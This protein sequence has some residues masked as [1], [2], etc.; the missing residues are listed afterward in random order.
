MRK[1][2]TPV[3]GWEQE[4]ADERPSEFRGSTGYSVLSG[5]HLPSELN[6]RAARRRRGTGMGFKLVVI[7]FLALLAV[8]GVAIHEMIKLLRA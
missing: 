6:A 5:Y 8:S 1:N 3:Y 2:T 7:V 4:P